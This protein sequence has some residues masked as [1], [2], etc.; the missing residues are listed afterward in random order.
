MPAPSID[1]IYELGHVL[2]VLDAEG[3]GFTRR[4]I[5]SIECFWT[6]GDMHSSAAGFVLRLADRRRA[7]VDFLHW[8]PFE[9]NED[10]RIQVEPLPDDDSLPVLASPPGDITGGV[11]LPVGGWSHETAHLNRMLQRD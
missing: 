4:D 7:Y 6:F 10:F 5:A 3:H 8:H 2:Y 9:Q 1:G 11:T